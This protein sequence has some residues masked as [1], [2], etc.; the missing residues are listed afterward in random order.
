WSRY[1]LS[2]DGKWIVFSTTQDKPGEQTGNDGP[3]A[4]LRKIPADGGKADQ[5]VRFPSRVHD[6]CWHPDGKSLIVVSELGG[7]H[8][9]LWQLPLSSPLQG[10][11]HWTAG[12]ADE[13]RPSISRDG[14]RLVYTDNRS[15]ATALLLRDLVTGLEHTVA[16]RRLDYRCPTGTLRLRTVDRDA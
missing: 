5:L 6:L 12:Q 4:D 3:Q 13:D 14:K 11:K 16:V 9:D 8:Y 1:A 15:G 10:L 7:T 2:P